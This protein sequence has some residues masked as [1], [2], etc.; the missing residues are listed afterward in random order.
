LEYHWEKQNSLTIVGALR[1]FTIPYGVLITE[2]EALENVDEKPNFH[3]L[4]NTGLYILEQKILSLVSGERF[5]DM[6]DL[7]ILAK[8]ND[9]KVGVYPHHGRWFDV[10][11]W[12]EYHESLRAFELKG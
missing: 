6:T 1:K 12:E 7:I 11:Q 10:G 8:E 2:G 3:F 9:L 4:V 5:L